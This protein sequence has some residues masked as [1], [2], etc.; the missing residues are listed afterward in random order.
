MKEDH[1]QERESKL[2]LK[3]EEQCEQEL[4]LWWEVEEYWCKSE[5]IEIGGSEGD[6][7][8]CNK[9]GRSESYALG[10]EVSVCFVEE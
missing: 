1:D 6:G 10:Q 4:S 8:C 2:K 9:S 7:H 3:S 5:K